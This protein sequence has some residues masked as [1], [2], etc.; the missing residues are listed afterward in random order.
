MTTDRHGVAIP[1]LALWFGL[2]GAAA[3]WS[4]QELLGYVLVARS[5]LSRAG[6]AAPAG[7]LGAATALSVG[8]LLVGGVAGLVAYRIWRRTAHGRV[9]FMALSGV[10]VSGLF[11]LGLLANLV[12]LFLVEPCGG[13]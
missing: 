5:C 3:A 11:G 13:R 12:V 7:A 6:G 8:L 1:P 2:F 10:L 9:H 4:V